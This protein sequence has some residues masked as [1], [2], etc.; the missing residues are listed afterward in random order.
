MSYLQS[1]NPY[2]LSLDLGIDQVD[3]RE[4]SYD[5]VRRAVHHPVTP[6]K[7]QGRE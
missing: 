6:G 1:L 7:Q 4:T 3:A 2:P 5:R